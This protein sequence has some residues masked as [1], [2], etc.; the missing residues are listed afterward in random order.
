[1]ITQENKLLLTNRTRGHTLYYYITI[2]DFCLSF[3]IIR[4]IIL[5]FIVFDLR[6]HTN[7]V[8]NIIIN[9]YAHTP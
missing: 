4:C 3:S 7:E 2:N 6:V 5:L 9:Y 1:M 8:Y